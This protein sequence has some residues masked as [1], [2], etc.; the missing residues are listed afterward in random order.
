MVSLIGLRA[1]VLSAKQLAVA[2]V[3][4]GSASTQGLES[5]LWID[6]IFSAWLFDV[7]Q[8]HWN[9]SCPSQIV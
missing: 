4:Q 1:A 6:L 5:N 8:L 2:T 9:F 3:L 7:W